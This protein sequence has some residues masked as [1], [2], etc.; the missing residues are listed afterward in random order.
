M[1]GVNSISMLSWNVWRGG[2]DRYKPTQVIPEREKAIRALVERHHTTLGVDT[3][4]LSDAY[5][6]GKLYGSNEAVA[7]HLGY[8]NAIFIPLNDARVEAIVGSGAGN[9]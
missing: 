9:V 4:F 5:R 3:L 1:S 7:K 2:F 8:R 6:W